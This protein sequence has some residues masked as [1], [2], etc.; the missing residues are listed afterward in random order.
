MYLNSNATPRH[1][2]NAVVIQAAK[3]ATQFIGL[4]VMPEFSTDAATGIYPKIRLAKGAVLKKSDDTKRAA[5]GSYNEVTRSYE[6]DT[7]DCVDRGLEERID[8]A[9]AKRVKRYFDAESVTAQLILMDIMRGHESRVATTIQNPANFNSTNA[10]VAYTEANVATIDFQT[11]LGNALE[12]LQLKGVEA[13]T[14]VLT[15]K[16]W[17]RLRRCSRLQTFLYGNL[18]SGNQRIIRP[19]D[20]KEPFGLS[21]ILIATASYDSAKR[22][23]A[24]P[25]LSTIWS[26][27]Y[28]W[29]GNVQSGAL[30]TGGAGR[31]MVWTEDSD[32]FTTETYRDEKRRSD[33]VR[34][35]HNT[36]EKVIDETAGELIATGL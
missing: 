34:V 16:L 29:V 18:P 12:R 30:E 21:N 27:S 23:Q 33:M 22:G 25:S 13:N 15:L 31:T 1:D 19:D 8:D 24:N 17:N 32:L 28:V 26:D 20:L 11:D 2:I 3:S 36:A 9:L 6:Y 5:N 4:Q 14:L 10:S 7:Y 35:R